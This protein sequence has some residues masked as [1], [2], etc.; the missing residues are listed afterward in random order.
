MEPQKRKF[1]DD[2]SANERKRDPIGYFI[3][4][5]DLPGSSDEEDDDVKNETHKADRESAMSGSP[6]PEPEEV[7]LTQAINTAPIQ[8]L[9]S[10]LLLVLQRWIYRQA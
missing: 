5:S 6:T 9:R 3:A 4:H 8:S 1:W 2:L 7:S 10:I